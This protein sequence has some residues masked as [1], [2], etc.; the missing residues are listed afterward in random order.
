MNGRRNRPEQ[1]MLFD[2]DGPEVGVFHHP[3]P[4]RRGSRPYVLVG[5]D[6]DDPAEDKRA[7][8][9]GDDRTLRRLFPHSWVPEEHD[10]GGPA[11]E[12]GES[13]VSAGAVHHSHG[14]QPGGTYV[15][16]RSLNRTVQRQH[17]GDRPATALDTDGTHRLR[18]LQ[19]RSPLREP[20]RGSR[21]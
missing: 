7:T 3:L 9:V 18:G 8:A 16:R 1:L 17:R 15:V 4:V 20:L 14:L 21:A 13:L 5:T 12:I 11:A 10:L 6:P 2:L 19:P